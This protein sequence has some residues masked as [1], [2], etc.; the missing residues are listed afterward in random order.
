MKELRK[1][2]IKKKAKGKLKAFKV[3]ANDDGKK[4]LHDHV[5][6]FFDV[7]GYEIVCSFSQQ[8]KERYFKMVTEH[9]KMIT[10]LFGY[11]MLN[12]KVFLPVALRKGVNNELIRE[13]KTWLDKQ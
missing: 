13:Y 6:Y 3:T 1:T 12:S 11:S 5:T 4:Y 2:F 7:I 10:N 9:E 8:D